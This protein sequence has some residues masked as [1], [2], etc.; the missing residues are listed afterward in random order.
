MPEQKNVLL[1]T[2]FQSNLNTYKV[3]HMGI[4]E[5]NYRTD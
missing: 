5:L 1:M 4:L 3:L 2:D